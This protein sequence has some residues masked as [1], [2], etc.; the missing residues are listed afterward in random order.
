MLIHLIYNSASRRTLGARNT[1]RAWFRIANNVQNRFQ[2][3]FSVLLFIRY[4]FF[5]VLLN[6]HYDAF[7]DFVRISDYENA[8]VLNST[9]YSSGANIN[10]I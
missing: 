9:E 5:Y 4:S 2:L 10:Y 1:S 7:D 8:Q 3:Q 6:L